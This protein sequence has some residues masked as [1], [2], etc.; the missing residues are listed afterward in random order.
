[1]Q[2]FI[3]QLIVCFNA[4]APF[5]LVMGVGWLVR[6]VGLV[7][8]PFFAGINKLAFNCLFPALIFMT[9]F[10]AD[11]AAAFDPAL[12]TYFI[13]G[14]VIVYLLLW[15]IGARFIKEKPTLAVFVQ[16]GYRSN[17]IILAIAVIPMLLGP[18]AAPRAAL[19][20]TV[21][22]STYSVLAAIL[23]VSVGLDKNVSGFER[24]KNVGI[25]IITMPVIIAAVA[26]L[27]ANFIALPLPLVLERGI[28]SVADMAAPAALIGIGGALSME[29]VRRNLRMAISITLVKNILVPIVL[30]IPAILLGFRGVDLAII[31]MI[32][33]SPVGAVSYVTAAAMGGDMDAAASSLVLSNAV[34]IFTV[35]LG[36]TILRVFGLF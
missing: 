12:A 5:F 36:L 32:G 3:E 6:R 4:V 13:I 20:T 11:L 15:V 30:T 19:M 22:V 31:A 34:A 27:V 9:I 21:T 8:D 18:E 14:I 23:F 1:M 28:S 2:H 16:A 7:G 25:G 24:F 10:P 26:G 35:V 29:K 33:L 17:Y